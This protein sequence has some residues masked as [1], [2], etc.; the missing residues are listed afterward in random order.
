MKFYHVIDNRRTAGF[1]IAAEVS[2]PPEDAQVVDGQ[3]V[4]RVDCAVSYCAPVEQNFSRPKGRLVAA[5]RLE[6]AKEMPS[7]KKFSFLTRS[8]DG[9]KAQA[10]ICLQG[11]M[12][13]DSL[14]WARSLV[15][16]ELSRLETLRE[17]EAI[18]RGDA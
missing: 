17:I 18:R 10:L 11:N 13:E 2:A 9:L 16:R 8:Q 15:N 6:N 7:F 3:S 12:P 5:R 14:G 1:T 4:V